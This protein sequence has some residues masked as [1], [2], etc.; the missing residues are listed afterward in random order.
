[1]LQFLYQTAVLT[2]IYSA[3]YNTF[4]IF[5]VCYLGPTPPTPRA[6]REIFPQDEAKR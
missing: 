1:M 2:T 6:G 4:S 3:I 5:S